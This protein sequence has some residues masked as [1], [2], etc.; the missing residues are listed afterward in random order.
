MFLFEHEHIGNSAMSLAIGAS[1]LVIDQP[2]FIGQAMRC[3]P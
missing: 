2:G 1:F 3:K